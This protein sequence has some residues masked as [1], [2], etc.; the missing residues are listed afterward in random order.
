MIYHDEELA[1]FESKDGIV[2][3]GQIVEALNA[4]GAG[5]CDVLFVH[6]DINFGIPITGLKRRELK[7]IMVD[8]LKELEVDTIIFPT[9]TFSFNNKE[10]YDIQNSHTKMGMLPEYVRT[11]E[12]AT[13]SDDPIMS[14]AI[15]GNSSGLLHMSGK[16]SCGT[17]GIFHQLHNSGKNVKFLFFGTSVMKCF[18]YLH[19]V[20]EIKQ[21]P[22]RYSRDFK[23]KVIDD[24]VMRDSE[25]IV[26]VRYKDVTPT[27]PAY[28]EDEM[29]RKGIEKK[30][31]LGNSFVSCVDEKTAYEY[32]CSIIDNNLYEFAIMPETGELIKEYTYG[33]VTTM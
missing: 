20:E 10:D 8:V 19:Y 3:Y 12:D 6:S 7:E 1:V 33:N 21:V 31:S 32:I 27:L 26:Y 15:I 11:R 16:S 18:T 13:R 23:G 25:V 24:G 14:V 5:A 29:I 17:G 4:C 9:F 28:L 2:T 22:Y 30:T